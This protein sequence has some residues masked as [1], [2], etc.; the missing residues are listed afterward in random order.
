[1]TS[2]VAQGRAVVSFPAGSLGVRRCVF[3]GGKGLKVWAHLKDGD[4]G[5]AV[6]H[7]WQVRQKDKSEVFGES[8]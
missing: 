3:G 4:A 7:T 5:F 1:M 6:D 2:G 8:V